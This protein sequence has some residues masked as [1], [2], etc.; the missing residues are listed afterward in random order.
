MQRRELFAKILKPV[1]PNT[2][3]VPQEQAKFIAPPYFSGEFDCVDCEAACVTACERE[4]L[5]FTDSGVK[6]E[7]GQKGCNFCEKCAVAC[8]QIGKTS[9]NLK[10]PAK[11]QARTSISVNSCLAWNEVICY[12]CQDACKFRAIE[13][14]GVFRPII[15]DRCTNCGD[16]VVACFKNSIEM[17][18]L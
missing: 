3:C 18:A 17:E 10:F 14:L 13:Y 4:L 1:L 6:F 2:A 11:I 16:C 7:I 15:N 5:K 9:L 8:E 12:N